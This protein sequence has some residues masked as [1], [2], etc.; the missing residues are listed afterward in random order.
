MAWPVSHRSVAAADGLYSF[1]TSSD[2]RQY[3]GRIP[4]KVFRREGGNVSA[5]WPLVRFV[6]GL[7]V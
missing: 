1:S 6:G 4:R 7:Q 2:E 3:E 5:L